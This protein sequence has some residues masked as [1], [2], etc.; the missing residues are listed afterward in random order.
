MF[1]RGPFAGR[2]RGGP[3]DG[4]DMEWS[5]PEFRLPVRAPLPFLSDFKPP[6]VILSL[7]W[8]SYRHVAGQWIWRDD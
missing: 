8:G 2:C 4:K 7:K 1:P 6:E 5:R 3:W